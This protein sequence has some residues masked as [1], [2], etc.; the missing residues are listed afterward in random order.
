[1]IEDADAKFHNFDDLPAGRG[2][3]GCPDKPFYPAQSNCAI[4]RSGLRDP[5]RG[6]V[7]QNI[8]CQA[9]QSSDL[10]VIWN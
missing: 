3:E 4:Q 10:M 2:A 7:L 9:C 1:M 8:F 6:G 5:A